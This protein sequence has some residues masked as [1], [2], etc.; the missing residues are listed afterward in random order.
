MYTDGSAH[1]RSK[2][3]LPQLLGFGAYAAVLIPSEDERTSLI[4]AKDVGT[5]TDNVECEVVGVQ[6]A[7][8]AIN[9]Y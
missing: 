3:Q 8:E 6:I 5:A 1:N 2:E 7:L 4:S 9:E